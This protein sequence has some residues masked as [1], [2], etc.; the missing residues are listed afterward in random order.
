MTDLAILSDAELDAVSG[1]FLNAGAGGGGGGGGTNNVGAN[2]QSS[3]EGDIRISESNLSV[4]DTLAVA[5]GGR[6]GNGGDVI[7]RVSSGRR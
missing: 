4:R 5:N 3:G 6:G 2:V 7:V 1:G